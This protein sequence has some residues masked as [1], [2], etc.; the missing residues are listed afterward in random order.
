MADTGWKSGVID[1]YGRTID[2]HIAS[3]PIGVRRALMAGFGLKRWQTR[4][5]PNRALYPS[6]QM[7]S[8]LTLE[9][10][11]GALEHPDEMVVTSIFLPSEPFLAMGLRPVTAEAI[12]QFMSGAWAEDGFATAAEDAG[13]PDTFCSYHRVLLGAA[14]SGVLQPA[15]MVASCSVA[16]DANNLTF[17]ELQRL[18]GCKRSYVDVPYEPTREA[19]RYVAVRLREMARVAEEAFGRT[20]DE[21]LLREM[22]VRSRETLDVAASTLPGRARIWVD[23]DMATELYFALAEHLLLGTADALELYRQQ[24]ADLASAPAFDGT[25]LLWIHMP[26]Y[27]LVPFQQAINESETVQLVACDMGFD[28]CRLDGDWWFDESDPWLMMAERLVR[29]S[30]NGPA[31][32]RIGHARR[33]EELIGADGVVVFC[34]WGCKQTMG[35][36]QLMRETFEADGVPVLVIDGDGC[37]R[38]GCSAGQLST[39]LDA[40]LE[41]LE[42]RKAAAGTQPDE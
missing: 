8:R 38:S 4:H 26:P 1:W 18:W 28:F 40:F 22:C 37:M 13:I 33:M 11:V 31:E 12:S 41:L 23:N 2:H 15:P 17:A 30:F 7:A 24:A 34:H 32:R 5:L 6:G 20:L 42:A 3:S 39:R 10:I 16:C 29:N 21:D 19:C 14:T 36:S 25:S 9:H 35:A 27:H